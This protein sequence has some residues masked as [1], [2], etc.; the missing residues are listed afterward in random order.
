MSINIEEFELRDKSE[1]ERLCK[2]L[3][4]YPKAFEAYELWCTMGGRK[5]RS[6]TSIAKF[7]RAYGFSFD[8]HVGSAIVCLNLLGRKFK[9]VKVKGTSP[10]DGALYMAFNLIEGVNTQEFV[11][12]ELDEELGNFYFSKDATETPDN[13]IESTIDDLASKEVT[14]II[15]LDNVKGSLETLKMWVKELELVD[16]DG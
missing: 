3:H 2:E 16:G 6:G 8:Y 9:A 15:D 4:E 10:E 11:A 14:L 1:G 13:V 5:S 12:L 7:L